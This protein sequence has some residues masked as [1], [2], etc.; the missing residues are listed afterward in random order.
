MYAPALAGAAGSP[1][2]FRCDLRARFKTLC[3]T[4]FCGRGRSTIWTV[5]KCK[6]RGFYKGGV[7]S[8]RRRRRPSVRNRKF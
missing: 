3:F 7:G 4:G 5:A 2:L 8:A 1:P 6:N